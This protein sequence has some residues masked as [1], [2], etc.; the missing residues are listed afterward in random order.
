[1]ACTPPPVATTLN[2]AQMAS[3]MAE[4]L[5]CEGAT[6]MI[7]GYKRDSIA[8]V[9]YE[10]VFAKQHTNKQ[11]YEDNLRILVGDIDRMERILTE[12]ER[13]LKEKQSLLP[14]VQ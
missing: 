10:E 5:L 3:I 14:T 9:Y 2:D 6:V 8:S 13:I 12:S 4:L 7:N 1:M 11:E